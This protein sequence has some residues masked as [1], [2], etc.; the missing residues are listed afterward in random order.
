MH[1]RLDGVA[2]G[3]GRGEVDALEVASV[4]VEPKQ[5]KKVVKVA[6]E[7]KGVEKL[8]FLSFGITGIEG[9]VPAVEHSNKRQTS[10]GACASG[11]VPRRAITLNPPVE[12]K[13]VWKTLWA[14]G[15]NRITVCRPRRFREMSVPGS[16]VAKI[17]PCR[18]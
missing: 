18:C 5:V 1:T 12:R 14:T 15:V 2:T 10:C 4:F 9:E 16:W 8:L 3:T 11:A 7:E 6:T 13:R 17:H